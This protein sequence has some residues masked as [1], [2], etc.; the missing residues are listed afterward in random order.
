MILLHG[1]FTPEL[2]NGLVGGFVGALLVL[3]GVL[4][5]AFRSKYYQ[6]E[7]RDR[8]TGHKLFAKLIV[9]S[10]AAFLSFVSFFVFTFL[11]AW[12]TSLLR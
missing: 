1:G 11:V 5:Y 3:I 4:V 8:D 2:I 6:Q 10:F 9:I 12:I 7:I